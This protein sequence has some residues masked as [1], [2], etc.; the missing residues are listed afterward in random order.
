MLSRMLSAE[1]L[2]QLWLR[3]V[4]TLLITNAAINDLRFRS[5]ALNLIACC[6]LRAIAMASAS[7]V[8]G[9][10]MSRSKTVL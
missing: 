7:C 5:T 4:R 8:V 2:R 6:I 10:C 1:L 3:D 9:I